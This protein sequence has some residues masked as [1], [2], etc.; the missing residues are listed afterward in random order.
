M[1]R[2]VYFKRNFLDPKNV[3][4]TLSKENGVQNE[5][6]GHLFLEETKSCPSMETV[7]PIHCAVRRFSRVSGD[8]LICRDGNEAASIC[9]STCDSGFD[10]VP[11]FLGPQ[12]IDHN[13]GR[14]AADSFQRDL[15][16]ADLVTTGLAARCT[17]RRHRMLSSVAILMIFAMKF[18]RGTMQS[19]KDVPGEV[20]DV[21]RM[22]YVGPAPH[23]KFKGSLIHG[24]HKSCFP[25]TRRTPH[26][27][28]AVLLDQV[29]KLICFHVAPNQG[30]LGFNLFWG[31][32]F[33]SA[34][35]FIDLGQKNDLLKSYSRK[36]AYRKM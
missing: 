32:S 29:K 15:A 8:A 34:P 10:P 14:P 22:G 19:L 7:E 35:L 33:L 4:Q 31:A 1:Y 26:C 21:E 5:R 28:M 17:E 13:E 30:R 11:F 18:H 24:F 2:K 9:R 6:W 3:V 23:R 12:A 25:N 27:D 36:N 16:S 20:L